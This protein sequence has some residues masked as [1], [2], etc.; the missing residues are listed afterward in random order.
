MMQMEVSE[1]IAA[2][3]RMGRVVMFRFDSS[4][5]AAFGGR[6]LALGLLVTWIVGMG[7]YW[8]DDRARLLQH[9]GV[10]SVIYVFVLAAVLWITVA[11]IKAGAPSYFR[12][13]TFVTYTALPAIFYAIPV[14]KIF[15]MRT[16]NEINLA[17]LAVV[18]L[19][20]L[21]LYGVFLSRVVRLGWMSPF[22]LLLP[23][24]LIVTSLVQL[25]LHHVVFEIMGG[26]RVADRS[27]HDT[28]YF[29][30]MLLTVLSVPVTAVCLIVW[31]IAAIDRVIR[32]FRNR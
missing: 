11:A 3:R 30:L 2:M 25:N 1:W 10:G 12:F 6:D 15:G 27:V 29:I 31:L 18:A 24:G 28:S 5:I 19:W 32:Y 4:D 7:R 17:F 23:I 20:R 21:S 9:L 26:L 22:V 13:L 14:E 16:G 8:D